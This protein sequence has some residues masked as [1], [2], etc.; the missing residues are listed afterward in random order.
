MWSCRRRWWSLWVLL[1]EV[2]EMLLEEWAAHWKV[3]GLVEVG[4]GRV[5][6]KSAQ[7]RCVVSR[8]FWTFYIF[9]ASR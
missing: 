9:Q 6:L 4:V 3:A 7:A 8:E 5:K 1:G 2:V